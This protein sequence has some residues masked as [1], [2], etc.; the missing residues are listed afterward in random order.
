MKIKMQQ[1]LL[2]DVLKD[3]SNGKYLFLVKPT[4]SESGKKA[5][6][7]WLLGLPISI[8]VDEDSNTILFGQDTLIHIVDFAEGKNRII[9]KLKKGIKSELLL[10]S[11]NLSVLETTP[12][13]DLTQQAKMLRSLYITE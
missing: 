13:V 6:L 12:G 7:R 3:F 8:I 2:K 11:I 1:R 4:R 10:K 5:M 9:R